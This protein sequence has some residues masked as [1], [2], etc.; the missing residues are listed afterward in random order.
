MLLGEGALE[1]DFAREA[2]VHNL[3]GLDPRGDAARTLAQRLK[4]LG[5]DFAIA[6]TT[7]SGLFAATLSEAGFKVVSLVH[8]L[9]KIIREYRLEGHARAIAAHSDTVIAAADLVAREFAKVSGLPRDNILIRPQGAYKRN[10]FRGT[11]AEAST[12]RKLRRQLG[13]PAK[14][15]VVLGVGFADY[16]KGFDLFVE[17]AE[18][19]GRAEELVF[20]WAGHHEAEL[21]DKLGKRLTA[22]TKKGTLIL[23]GRLDDTDAV[24]AAADAYVLTSREDPFPTTVM[25]ALDVGLPVFGFSDV[26]GTDELIVSFGGRLV[27]PFDLDALANAL[28]ESFDAED[29]DDRV[30]R[31]QSFWQR[32][33]TSFSAYVHELL[34]FGGLAPKRVSVVVPN[35]NYG[36]FL[37][38]RIDSIL[39]QNHPIGEIIVL[40][41]ASSDDSLKRLSAIMSRIEVPVRLVVNEANSGSVFRQWLKGAELARYDYLW[42]AEADD[43][44]EPGFLAEALKGFADDHVVLS[45]TQSKQMAQDGRILCDDY[46]DYVND[47]SPTQ[48]RSDYVRGGADEIVNGLSI[49]N[50]IPNVSAVVFR[51]Q[52]FVET[53]RA[54][55]EDIVQYRVAGDWC[56]YVHLLEKGSCRFSARSLNLHRRHDS[57]VTLKSFSWKELNEIEQM[58]KLVRRMAD[59][60]D[61]HADDARTYLEYLKREFSL[62]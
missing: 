36:H 2:R 62:N 26:A 15:R 39:G 16:R 31:A 18:R 19:I 41:D 53:M 3:A 30:A 24:Y 34:A 42:I 13:W 45:Y 22:L 28:V 27:P 56:T 21:H 47:V 57:S 6:N 61:R 48:W 9:P 5:A 7:V 33:D 17:L 8:E 25:E 23:P 50:T 10:R 52:A 38:E 20:V 44:C 29:P 59:G 1:A 60:A 40:D 49:K 43:L 55:L 58:Q 46:L 11:A 51:R 12:Q 37:D 32:P 14:A 4:A 54:H 35:Y